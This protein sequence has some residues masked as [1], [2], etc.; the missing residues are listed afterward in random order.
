MNSS[1]EIEDSV[2]LEADYYLDKNSDGE[3]SLEWDE[4]SDEAKRYADALTNKEISPEKYKSMMKY[5][6]FEAIS[7][8]YTANEMKEKLLRLSD[9]NEFIEK[10]DMR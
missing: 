9:D 10:K 6:N 5:G 3:L 7:G 2:V 4:Y 8:K 1:Y